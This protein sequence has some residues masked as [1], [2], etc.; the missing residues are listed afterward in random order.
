V[1]LGIYLFGEPATALRMLCISLIVVG[2]VGLRF[3]SPG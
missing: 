3:A 2:I 1:A